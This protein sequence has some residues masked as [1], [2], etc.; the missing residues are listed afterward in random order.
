MPCLRLN[1]NA[2]IES[3][4]QDF[5]TESIK[6]KAFKTV[7]QLRGIIIQFMRYYN[8]ERSH[9]KLGYIT[10]AEFECRMCV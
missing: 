8:Y 4:F 1:D 7:E 5:K 2:H 3:F 9:S 6:V 10:P